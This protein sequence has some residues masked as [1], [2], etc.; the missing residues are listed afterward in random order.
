MSAVTPETI[1]DA[2][3]AKLQPHTT[4]CHVELVTPEDAGM[5]SHVVQVNFTLSGRNGASREFAV[6]SALTDAERLLAKE[7]YAASE[8]LYENDQCAIAEA[9][10]QIAGQQVQAAEQLLTQVL[11]ADG[12]SPKREHAAIANAC[13]HLHAA[14]DTESVLRMAQADVGKM[15]ATLIMLAD[16]FGSDEEE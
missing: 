16:M 11:N 5:D 3:L 6:R 10:M 13:Q 8:D 7:L 4:A 1:T 2:I 14:N 9:Q 15:G 12:F